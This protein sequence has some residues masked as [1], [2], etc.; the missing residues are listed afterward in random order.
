[1][2]TACGGGQP[3]TKKAQKLDGEVKIDNP[4]PFIID[5][6]KAALENVDPGPDPDAPQGVTAAPEE[7]TKVAW[8]SDYWV[9]ALAVDDTHVYVSR[10]AIPRGGERGE[11]ARA[12]LAG[13]KLEIVLGD[14]GR[15]DELVVSGD[16]LF[17]IS[18]P[19]K[20][21]DP[22]AGVRAVNK[23]G[24][25]PRIVVADIRI[26][27]SL[28]VSD[29]MVYWALRV[30]EQGKV[31]GFAGVPREGGEMKD[32]HRDKGPLFHLRDGG[33]RVFFMSH[34]GSEPDII[35]SM[36]PDGSDLEEH[37]HAPRGIVALE[38]GKDRIYWAQAQFEQLETSIMSAPRAGGKSKTHWTLKGKLL[39]QVVPVGDA[40]WTSTSA[41]EDMGEVFVVPAAG[42]DATKVAESRHVWKLF[43]A[44]DTVY[45]WDSYYQDNKKR[46]R[47]RTVDP[48]AK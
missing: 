32:F 16:E 21:G 11:I 35:Y 26:E 45:W 10:V 18:R 12:P 3:D 39:D 9:K 19:G 46:H 22:P 24:G 28:T 17:W 42:G 5:P 23:S 1:V 44:A 13:G 31:G 30:E 41:V 14:L 29:T 6:D 36:K 47:V 2:F 27:H 25:E 37:H 15:P 4:R 43:V 20:E 7:G 34:V 40:I 33:D 38:P 48:A 8:D